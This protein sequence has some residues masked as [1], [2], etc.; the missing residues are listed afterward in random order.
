MASGSKIVRANVSTEPSCELTASSFQNALPGC[1]S[2]VCLCE[3]ED[4]PGTSLSG[5]EP[6]QLYVVE[7]KCQLKCRAA[8]TIGK[9]Q[10]L[11]KW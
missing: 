2:L 7:L 5:C 6:G 9:K 8:T 11:V 4:V 1:S 10:D 3:E